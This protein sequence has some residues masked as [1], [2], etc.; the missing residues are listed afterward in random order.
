MVGCGDKDVGLKGLH[1]MLVSQEVKEIH[2]FDSWK[3]RGES[4]GLHT[5][6]QSLKVK[7]L[8]S[9]YMAALFG[10]FCTKNSTSWQ[11]FGHTKNGN[12]NSCR[13]VEHFFNEIL[14]M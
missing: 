7:G 12:L 1:F 3:V 8:Q 10:T 5:N 6:G 13:E 9:A 2:Q 14:K 11:E 4:L